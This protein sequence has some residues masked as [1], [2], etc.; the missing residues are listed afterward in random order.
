MS[1]FKK[2]SHDL[3]TTWSN[4]AE[5]TCR[6]L[7]IAGL[8][9]FRSTTNKNIAGARIEVDLG[10]DDAG[11]VYILWRP[12][13]KLSQAAA[14]SVRSGHLNHHSVQQSGMVSKVMHDAIL[15][16]LNFSGFVAEN[17]ADDLR[18]FSIRVVSGPSD[19]LRA[20]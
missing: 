1:E 3:E 20:G 13:P 18:P 8:P 2:V 7:Q 4:L 9:T 14:D 6:A 19:G 17:P 11:G 5:E 10:D 15:S 16:I 12:D